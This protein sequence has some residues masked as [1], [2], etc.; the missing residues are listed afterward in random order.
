MTEYPMPYSH[1]VL[2]AGDRE[3]L[4]VLLDRG[5]Y[6]PL[7]EWKAT[8]VSKDEFNRLMCARRLLAHTPDYEE[9]P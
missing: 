1:I 5:G 2:R 4:V 8:R 9:H 7:E 6:M 3:P